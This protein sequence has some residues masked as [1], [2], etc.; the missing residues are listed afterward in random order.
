MA[1]NKSFGRCKVFRRLFFA[2]ESIYA[3]DFWYE[4]N[5]IYNF[6]VERTGHN[7]TFDKKQTIF[8]YDIPFSHTQNILRVVNFHIRFL[9]HNNNILVEDNWKNEE[10]GQ[11]KI[12]AK[13]TFIV[14]WDSSQNSWNQLEKCL[15]EFTTENRKQYQEC[16]EYLKVNWR[17][18]WQTEWSYARRSVFEKATFTQPIP[19]YYLFQPILLI[20][21]NGTV[22]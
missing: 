3:S 15:R 9:F 17:W 2:F 4:N 22:P 11:G 20:S 8:N 14:C 5:V 12:L 13:T 6:N 19:I 10:K 18:S 7:I 1:K 21:V 16:H